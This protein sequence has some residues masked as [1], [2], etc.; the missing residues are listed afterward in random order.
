MQAWGYELVE[1]IAWVKLRKEKIYLTHGYYFMHSYELCLIGY[2]NTRKDGH[3]MLL[4][5]GVNPNVVFGDVR[6]KSQKPEDIYNIIEM[7]FKGKRKL[8]I[9][10]R[11]HNLRFGVFSIG[12]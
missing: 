7:V 4:R 10:A 2:K 6:K 11:N 5:H 1:E 9:F 3:S 8:E 12:N